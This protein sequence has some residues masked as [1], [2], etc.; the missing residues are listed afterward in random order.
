MIDDIFIVDEK[1]AGAN[2][3]V[4]YQERKDSLRDE[5]ARFWRGAV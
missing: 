1:R 4:D 5:E 2:I 3:A